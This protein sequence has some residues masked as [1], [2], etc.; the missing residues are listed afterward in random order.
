MGACLGTRCGEGSSC[1]PLLG[2]GGPGSCRVMGVH[3]EAGRHTSMV[4]SRQTQPALCS[5]L[6]AA[7]SLLV[8]TFFEAFGG[9]AA[10]RKHPRECI[11]HTSF[12]AYRAG[13]GQ[14]GCRV[15]GCGG[16]GRR[17]FTGCEGAWRKH[18]R[19]M[20][21]CAATA[22]ADKVFGIKA[23]QGTFTL[24]ARVGV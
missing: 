14:V 3:L 7:S 13:A 12:S 9:C 8:S 17:V 4:S 16:G 20:Q 6:S 15:D 10:A 1:P 21:K 2:A 18:V 5:V 23:V 11:D 19:R 24:P 22:V